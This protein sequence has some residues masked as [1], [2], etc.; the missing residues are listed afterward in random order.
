MVQNGDVSSDKWTLIKLRIVTAYLFKTF[1]VSGKNSDNDWPR[2]NVPKYA[3]MS[4]F[5]N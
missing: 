4:E 1:L 2:L 5:R 3:V